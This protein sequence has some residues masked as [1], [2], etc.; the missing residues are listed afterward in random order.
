MPKKKTEIFENASEDE[1]PAPAPEPEPVADEPSKLPAKK[2]R[3]KRQMTPEQKL[4][5]I[6]NLK[7]GRETAAANRKRKAELK[8]IERME[9][10]KA[11]DEKIEAYKK[12]KETLKKIEKEPEPEPAPEPEPEKPKPKPKPKGRSSDDYES[13]IAKL[14]AQLNEGHLGQNRYDENQQQGNLIE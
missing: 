11:E 1:A 10:R 12:K 5:A 4:K 14:K 7:K 13:E 3:K 9:Q 2:P 8:R 6:E